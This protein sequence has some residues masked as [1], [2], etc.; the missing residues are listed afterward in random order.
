G[1]DGQG[2]GQSVVDEARGGVDHLLFFALGEDDALRPSPQPLVDALENP[3]HR[4]AARA[5]L[6]PVSIHVDDGAPGDAAVHGG[7]GDGGRGGRDQ[8]RGE[9]H[10][11]AGFG[12][13]FRP[14]AIGGGDLVGNVLARK[15]GER[16]GGGD[17]HLH[18]DGGGAHVERAAKDVG[19]AEHVVD[20]VGIVGASGRHDGVAA[21][22][23]HFLGGGFTIGICHC[24]GDHV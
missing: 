19:K 5:Q 12:A 18:V 21:H 13:V 3:G 1:A 23:R 20:L 17:L 6:R 4:I 15:L 14:R 24:G 16:V 7:G 11:N 8:P 22:L 9:R 2:C 10:R